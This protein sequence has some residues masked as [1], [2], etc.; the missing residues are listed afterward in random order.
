MHNINILLTDDSLF[1]RETIKELLSKYDEINQIFTAENGK[2]AVEICE[3]EK[4]DVVFMDLDMPV[5]DGEKASRII[6]E[7]FGLPIIVLTSLDNNIIKEAF[8]LIHNY[9]IDVINKPENIN[10]SFAKI[11]LRKIKNAFIMKKRISEYK[12]K[13]KKVKREIIIPDPF[14]TDSNKIIIFA[15]STGGP[16]ITPDILKQIEVI[17]SPF[18]LIQHIEPMMFDGYIDWLRS[19][20]NKEVIAVDFDIPFE[21]KDCLYVL[22]PNYHTTLKKTILTKFITKPHLE[23]DLYSPPADPFVISVAEIFREKTI[24]AIFSGMCSDGLKGA[25]AVK[26]YGGMVFC[27]SPDEALIDTMPKSV[28]NAG[29]CDKV[30]ELCSLN[31]VLLNG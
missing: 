19:K 13:K 21:I 27:Q 3:K 23:T 1:V 20:T 24:F 25:E 7:K 8:D 29:F 2:E 15:M 10:E 6:F 12:N 18:V 9:C 30:F 17:P 22:H 14:E 11:L 5:M 26:K 28:L 4:I 31:E 16:K